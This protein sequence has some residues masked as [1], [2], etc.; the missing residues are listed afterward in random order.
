MNTSN[1]SQ[2]NEPRLNNLNLNA[3]PAVSDNINSVE[4]QEAKLDVIL[5]KANIDFEN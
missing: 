1:F 2:N 3:E 5:G 4:A